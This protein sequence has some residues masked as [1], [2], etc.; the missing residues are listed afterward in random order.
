[1]FSAPSRFA[2]HPDENIKRGFVRVLGQIAIQARRLTQHAHGTLAASVHDTRI[3]IKYLRAL[4]LQL[5]QAVP[6]KRMTGTI[7]R[8]DKLQ[9]QLGD[10]HDCVI[11]QDRLQ[12]SLPLE[13]PTLV[14]RRTVKFLEM[15]K[16]RL[17]K[18]VR[19]IAR[20]IELR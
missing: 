1:M 18:S 12:R 4:Q 15:R 2:F 11:A 13:V 9:E 16:G 6:G 14:V 10:Y 20:H 8:I 5:T 7:K 19:E 17:R 3:L